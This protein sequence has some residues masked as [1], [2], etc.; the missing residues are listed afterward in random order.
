M[1]SA[2]AF[3]QAVLDLRDLLNT[4]LDP[5]KVAIILNAYKVGADAHAGQTRKSGEAYILHPVEVAGILARMRMDYASVAAAILHDTLED[6]YLDKPQISQQFG[7]EI[8]DLVDGVTKLDKIKFRTRQEA[9]AESFRKLLLA[10]SADL[11]VIFIKL[12][13]RLHNMRTLG[14]MQPDSQRRI[15]RET[16]SIYAP[17]A[18]RLGMNSI[19]SELEELGFKNLHPWRYQVVV[20][21]V[22]A[23]AG[24]RQVIVDS[25]TQDIKKRL[26]ES[27]LPQRIIGREKTP[28]S[29]YMKM[30]TQ[31]LSFSEVTDVYAFRIITQSVPHCYQALGVA[32]NLYQPKQGA[33][34]DYI[35]LPKAN[36]YQS[37]HTVLH[38]PY[39]VPVEIQIRTEEMDIVAEQGAAAHWL[40]KSSDNKSVSTAVR[41][42]QWLMRLVDIQKHTGDSLEF[43]EDAKSD[44]FP[45]EIF[46]FTPKGKI[47]SL[48]KGASALDF[49]Y[50]IHTQVGDQAKAAIVDKHS[51]PLGTPLDNGQTI[52]IET[53]ENAQPVTEWLQ[54]VATAKARAAIRHHLKSLGAEDTVS[55]GNQLLEK[56]L[57]AR[58]SSLEAIS[59]RRLRKYLKKN[60]YQ[61]IEELFADLALGQQLANLT[62][63]VLAPDKL[64]RL[65][66]KGVITEALTVAGSEGSALNFANCCHPIP[67]DEVMAYLSAGKGV[68]VHRLECNNVGEYRKHPDRC[69]DVQWA[70]ITTGTFEV[71]LTILARNISGVLASISA[72]IGDAGANIEKVQQS[73]TNPDTATLLFHVLV[74]DRDHMAK[75]IRRLRRNANVLRVIRK[76]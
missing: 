21:Q 65:S 19:K 66:S 43:L 24:E 42:R 62:A 74:Q 40:Y 64:R 6:T 11:R 7:D 31:N 50:A 75:V 27:G 58:N 69:L 26:D 8:A 63:E 60:R 20:K 3:P 22:G 46:V 57:L 30:Q 34:K 51:V 18:D 29:I 14:S 15:A 52:T 36:G 25:I 61:N 68:V 35:A 71:A 47:I 5:D 37:L 28:Y 41:A 12:A 16:L 67:G 56:A 9:D 32:H 10:M 54:I 48:R 17:I 39:S 55:L 45:D 38:S 23:I 76:I 33:F 44:L 13:D 2:A 73:E 4:Y 70:G 72:S 53:D 59:S 49:A 1:S